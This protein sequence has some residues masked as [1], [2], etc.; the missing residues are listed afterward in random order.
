LLAQ[1]RPNS[2]RQSRRPIQ[3]R[4]IERSWLAIPLAIVVL[5]VYLGVTQ[6]RKQRPGMVE[7]F[8]VTTP[9]KALPVRPTQIALPGT[10]VSQAGRDHIPETAIFL[11]A[12][13]YVQKLDRYEPAEVK[14]FYDTHIAR[15]PECQ[16]GLCPT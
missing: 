12:W 14:A 8:T 4:L 2:S 3:E 16:E 10:P 7:S 6:G 11:T 1:F 15:G 9:R 5:V 13:G